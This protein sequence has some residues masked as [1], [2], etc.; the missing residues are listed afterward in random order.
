VKLAAWIF[1]PI[2]LAIAVAVGLTLIFGGFR[3]RRAVREFGDAVQ[4]LGLRTFDAA[5]RRGTKGVLLCLAV[6]AAFL[7][8]ARPQYGKG[9]RLV[10]ATNLDVVI[11]LDFSKSM[12]AR[13]VEPSRIFRAKV[14][15]ARLVKQL[16][17]ARFGAVAF[18]GEPVSFPLS[19]DGAAVAQFLRQLEPNDMPVGG[20][21][22]ARALRAAH[23]LLKRDPL[24]VDHKCVVVLVTDGE[25]LEGNP[26]Q[27]AENIAADGTTVH[28]VQIGGRSPEP[29]PFIGDDGEVH[30]W[31]KDRSGK[32]VTTALSE[33]GEQQLAA[34]AAA[35]PDGVLIR[36]EKGTTGLDQIVGELKRQMKGELSE[37][38]EHVYADVYFYPLALALLLLLAEVF[39]PEAP[40]RLFARK[41]PPPAKPRLGLRPLPGTSAM[42]EV[43]RAS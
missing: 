1:I 26:V 30:G 38:I 4:V 10:P 11:V 31:Q 19:A 20:T 40:R 3:A 33:Q 34:V 23:E 5:K 29:I 8:A 43:D 24:S 7:A 41:Q 36:A 14:E 21:A 25:D 27:A 12:Y 6:L 13:D 37:H 9:T 32:T 17:G 22:I 15:V 42:K 39:V 28:V 16:R 35:S 2:G 18:A